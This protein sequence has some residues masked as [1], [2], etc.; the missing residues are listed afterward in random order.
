M[1]TFDAE[2]YRDIAQERWARSAAGWR[3]RRAQLQQAAAPVSQWLVE[4]IEP[5]PGQTVLELA[6]GPGDTGMMAA[7]LIA[8]GGT[9][10][11]SDVA[12]PM[13]DVARER[14][15]ELGVE[16]VEFRTLNAEW[17]DLEA[18]S[19]DAVLCRWGYM[20]L[21]DP[22]AALRETR[23]VLRPGGRVAFA[24]WGSGEENEWASLA[25]EEMQ[26][27]VGGPEPPPEQPGMF[28]LSAPGR[29]EALVD[30]AGFTELE[31]DAIEFDFTFADLDEWWEDRVTLSIPF[32]DAL[33][34]LDPEARERLRAAIDER[35]AKYARA[36]GSLR[37][38]ARSLVG[39]ATA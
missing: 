38:P 13:L 16:N 7:E 25:T 33:A 8:P 19:V 32:A 3:E 28:A 1:S 17:I 36:D 24:V 18:A 37:L 5:Q 12:E 26:R 31:L 20:L 30:D 14:A 2:S 6:A 4:A 10:I 27:V 9:L 35:L 34:E 11:C 21:A 23:R 39:A 29:I 22:A 15:Q